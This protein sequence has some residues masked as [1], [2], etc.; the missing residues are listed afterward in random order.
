[1]ISTARH[2]GYR[3]LVLRSYVPLEQILFSKM[4]L[5]GSVYHHQ[6]VKCIDTM[7]RG[8]VQHT[9]HNP[10]QCAFKIRGKRISFADAVE[11]LYVTDDEFFGQMRGF[12]D[13]Y[14]Q[15][16]LRR[17]RSRDLFVRCLEIS[18]RT[19]TNWDDGRQSLVDLGKLP[20]EL[21]D[22]EEEIHKSLPGAARSRCN[23]NDVGLSIPGLPGVK[24][25][26]AHIQ[27]TKTSEIEY[28]ESYFPLAGV[29]K[30]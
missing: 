22:V 2:K 10:G 4:T 28:I 13:D 27:T 26:Y 9:I 3:V 18:R 15:E 16:M 21:A 20:A 24:T 17:F 23:R 7:L 14:I 6:K 25:G 11:Y 29:Y 12:G 1:M 30:L 8:M 5:F 19:V